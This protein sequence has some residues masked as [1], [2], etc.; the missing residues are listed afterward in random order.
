MEIERELFAAAADQFLAHGYAGTSM[1]DIVEAAGMSKTTLYARFSSKEDL[2]RALLGYIV[3]R[4]YPALPA[5]LECERDT[6]LGEALESFADR[7]LATALA[8]DW[9][10][11][12]KLLHSEGARFPELTRISSELRRQSIGAITDYIAYCAERDGIACG[13]PESVASVFVMALRGFFSEA[14]VSMRA[15]SGAE[16]REFGAEVVRLLMAGRTSW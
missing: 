2:F 16:R 6:P 7:A 1:A 11:F 8:R 14:V 5:L 15:V 9:V 4:S 12:D 3:E 13:K 10:L